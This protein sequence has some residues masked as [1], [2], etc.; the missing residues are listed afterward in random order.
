MRSPKESFPLLIPEYSPIEMDPRYAHTYFDRG[1]LYLNLEEY[2]LALVDLRKAVE[3]D[4]EYS[5]F[6]LA[7]GAALL[8]M[9][10]IKVD[11]SLVRSCFP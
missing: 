2:D 8:T 11:D 6:Q 3:I 7:L 9:G 10:S 1:S 5:E 4:P